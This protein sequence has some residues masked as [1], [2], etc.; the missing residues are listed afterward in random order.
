[1]AQKVT[2]SVKGM[3][4]GMETVAEVGLERAGSEVG[5]GLEGSAFKS[6][7]SG[8]KSGSA[9]AD[10]KAGSVGL[11]SSDAA[12]VDETVGDSALVGEVGSDDAEDADS[13][14]F[15]DMDSG[16]LTDMENTGVLVYREK[17]I[18]KERRQK[19]WGYFVVGLLRGRKV[20]VS[21]VSTD[22]GG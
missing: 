17:F 3:D 21:L 20:R 9:E 15:D 5:K 7:V 14:D 6:P 4:Q 16:E 2:E 12:E 19:Y 1:M 18:S 10:E 8:G 22:A 13:L 11:N